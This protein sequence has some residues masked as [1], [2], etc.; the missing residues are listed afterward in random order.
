MPNRKSLLVTEAEKEAC[1][2][3]RGISTTSGRELSSNFFF[4][5]GKAP[6]EIHA[7]LR[8]TLGGHAPSYGTV[9]NWVAQF[10]RGDFSP[11]VMRLVLDDS[12]Q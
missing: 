1:Q 2:A 9:K 3:R 4:L 11:H 12:K 7:I 5:Q 6:K 10:K 8:E